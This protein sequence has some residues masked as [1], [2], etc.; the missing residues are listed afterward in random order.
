M[1]CTFT[2]PFGKY[3]FNKL[4][5]GL[6]VS[7]EVFQRVNEKVFDD[8][9]IGIYFDDDDFIVVGENEEEYETFLTS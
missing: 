4:P 6:N 8:L 7:P 1:Y 9:P 3:K 5:F 2:T